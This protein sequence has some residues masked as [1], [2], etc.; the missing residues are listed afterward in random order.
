MTE[1]NKWGDRY[2]STGQFIHVDYGFIANSNSP[3]TDA[4]VSMGSGEGGS[5]R[6]VCRYIGCN[7]FL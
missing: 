4:Q 6:I 1:F 3:I 5:D 2:E 7:N